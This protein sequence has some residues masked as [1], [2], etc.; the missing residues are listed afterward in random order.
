MLFG[1]KR[2]WV[3]LCVLCMFGS[4]VKADDRQHVIVLET[5]TA[6]I[7]QQFTKAFLDELPRLGYS[8]SEIEITRL[9]A[10]GNADRAKSLLADE[11]GR[12]KP[13]LVV[14]VATLASKVAKEQLASTEMPLVFMCVTD[15]VGAGLIDEIGVADGQPITGK[16]H[17]VPVGVKIDLVMRVLRSAKPDQ[18]IVR[19]GYI[20]TDYSADLSDLKRLQAAVSD[21][22]EIEFVPFKI[23]YRP[24]NENK[25]Y[26]LSQI[27]MGV[28]ALDSK[29]DFFWAPRGALAVLPE[30]DEIILDQAQSPLLVGA[31]EA[32]VEKG[33]LLH[34]TADP[35]AQ[36]VDVA[37]IVQKILQGES[38]RAIPSSLAGKLQFS[39]N[40]KTAIKNRLVI[41]SDML[42]L[43]GDK[44]YR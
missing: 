36:G 8:D 17:Y 43:A 39:I 23:P 28:D 29:V 40:L 13:D 26:L 1:V 7:V 30:Y 32:S 21:K 14:S 3:L 15:P 35:V 16:A 5:M 22:A 6:P 31:T 37:L 18:S 38:V 25:D 44:V 9:N 27:A 24:V 19:F 33:A 4:A 41:S 12:S 2:Y 10:D 11:I 20:Y 34:I 42:E